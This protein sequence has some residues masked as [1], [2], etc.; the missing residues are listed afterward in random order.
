MKIVIAGAGETGTHLSKMLSKEGQQ[1]TLLD[2]DNFKLIKL[3]N[4]LHIDFV[5]GAP[6]AI[7]SLK[8]AGV[9]DADLFVAVTPS[10]TEN[11]TACFLAAK[12]GAKKTIAR[13]D[14]SEYLAND[15]KQMFAEMGIT[16]LI[17][18]EMLAAQEVVH[19]LK[20]TWLREYMSFEENKM[21]LGGIK[22]RDHAN[23]LNK[24]FNSGYFDH[25]R[26]R[27]VAIK[28]NNETIIPKGSDVILSGDLV[29]FITTPEHLD[30]VRQ[31]TGKKL[32]E[33]NNIMIM[34]G[35]RI[36]ERIAECIPDAMR[37]KLIE[38]DKEKAHRLGEKLNNVLVVTGDGRDV[39]FLKEEDIE[40]M[41]AFVALTDN[42]EANI[43]ACS[44]A[45]RFG[46]LKTIAEVE[47]ME[48]IPMA[49]S[50]DV[51]AILN[52]KLLSASTIY[53]YTI[54]AKV[55]NVK[56]LTNVEAVVI[57]FI[58]KEGSYFTQ[59]QVK[60]LNLP[61]HVNI[62]GLIRGGVGMIVNG[63]TMIQPDDHVIIFCM[64]SSIPDL[65]KLF[66]TPS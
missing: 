36:A 39:D 42:S 66:S 3:R 52:K 33:V 32:Y 62:G 48:Y 5:L 10:E 20:A 51:G 54:N 47:N 19:A 12:L 30:F 59:T 45:K 16:S 58:V 49:E 43:L 23:V 38:I 24:P 34:G 60:N 63:S 31:E 50:L 35:S 7:H 14:N 6:T 21:V 2:N 37:V 13:I 61:D 40:E 65:S 26:F 17:Y 56:C 18:P 8:E 64:I 46:I 53:Q 11:M 9:Q 4:S 29:Y 1:I 55:S 25:S 22:I 28:R 44:V 27:I 15:Y 57:E 41:N